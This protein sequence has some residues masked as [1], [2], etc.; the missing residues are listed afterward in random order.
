MRERINA[1]SMANSP[2]SN[3]QVTL[4]QKKMDLNLS[5]IDKAVLFFTWMQGKSKLK[6]L[7]SAKFF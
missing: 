7:F 1:R 6:W 2:V 5:F 3:F 4:L